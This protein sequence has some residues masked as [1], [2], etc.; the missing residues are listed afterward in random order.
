MSPKA[1]RSVVVLGGG[2]A[3]MTAAIEL[4][5]SGYK[6]HLV[7]RAEHL[8]GLVRLHGAAAPGHEPPDKLIAHLKKELEAQKGITV[9]LSSR[10]TGFEGVCPDAK[11]IIESHGKKA[12]TV[13]VGAVVLAIGAK[14]F[15]PKRL[16]EF[17]YG[18]SPSIVTTLE[19]E[20]MLKSGTPVHPKTK[21]PLR[22]VGFV[23]CVGS[24]METRGNPWCSNV[25]CGVTIK[26]AVLLK[27][28]SPETDV[29]VYYMDIRTVNRGQEELYAESRI[30]GVKYSRG[31]PSE[32]LTRK[33]GTLIVRSEDASL[34]KIIERELDLL[35]LS[36][37]L[38]PQVG[39]AE[40]LKMLGQVQTKDGF[41][42]IANPETR[43]VET[44][45]K[46]VFVAGA[47]DFPKNIKD[48]R[49]QAKAAAM[50]ISM[51]LG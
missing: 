13:N 22:R 47:A 8:G 11:A 10:L 1:E 29:L 9:H 5:R 51:F 25:C 6:V 14:P 28:R 43:P 19:F 23:Q 4:A 7:E 50:E 16:L 35:V 15:D 17:K 48:A 32:I 33:D 30:M 42:P 20:G 49:T 40:L 46:G 38:E 37:G 36:I 39:G 26:Q 18:R 34:G 41:V 24:R 27:Q 12:T 21:A 2:V 31:I 3:G 45:F 44:G